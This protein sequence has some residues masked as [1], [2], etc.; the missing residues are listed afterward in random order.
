MQK[1]T[2][3][4]L[5]LLAS[6]T[7]AQQPEVTTQIDS[8]QIK[9]GS[10]FHLTVKVKGPS[11][12]QVSFPELKNIGQLEVLENYPT[13][14][15]LNEAQI[16]FIK[17]YALTQFDS[18]AYQIPSFPILINDKQILTDS[19]FV[20]VNTVEVD[21]LKQKLFDIK[22]VSTVNET[23]NT[24]IYLVVVLLVIALGVLG[25]FL[26][27]NKKP[28]AVKPEEMVFASP[29]ERAT[30]LLSI[31]ETKNLLV[32]GEIK[33]YYSELTD[34]TKSYIEE[35]IQIPAKESTT[36]ELIAGLKIA[37]KQKKLPVK[38]ETFQALEAI[39]K[40]ADLVKFAKSKP[41]DF[42]IIED[43]K[44]IENVIVSIDDSLPEE[45]IEEVKPEELKRQAE[46]KR[47]ALQKKKRIKI[48]AAIASVVVIVA[49][50]Y[51]GDFNLF[52]SSAKSM[53]KKEWISSEYGNPGVKIYTP[54]VLIRQD[55]EELFPKDVIALLQEM[56][57]FSSGSYFDDVNFFVATFKYKQPQQ[58]DLDIALESGMQMLEAQGAQDIIV[59]T[60]DFETPEGVKG[61]KAVG[62][63][64]MLDPITKR[65]KKMYYD[66]VAFSQDGGL[67][68]ILMMHK[69]GD[70]AAQQVTERALNSIELKK[71]VQNNE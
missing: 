8:T 71:A 18:G 15:L 40:N 13:D 41:L 3:F 62:T 31:L 19:G 70:E 46:L 43:R 2:T 57:V 54:D 56:Q 52:G 23:S 12:T 66:F 61:R 38:P 37:A 50:L 35:T 14:T 24:W 29:I 68:L 51:F 55:N 36:S 59:K 67:Q 10:E 21:T 63:V 25:Y 44:K 49:V 1:I 45:I 53:L 30:T 11:N 22:T 26:W 69:E 7:W 4:F 33:E 16:E 48:G 27:K 17:K 42:E 39:L 47:L 32:K 9:I 34:I 5:V 20:L 65:S 64:V 28:K 60:A 6:I 58:I